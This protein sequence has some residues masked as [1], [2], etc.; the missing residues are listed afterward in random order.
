MSSFRFGSMICLWTD[1]GSAS[2][3]D[4]I[5]KQAKNWPS[6]TS[7][8]HQR[9]TEWRRTVFLASVEPRTAGSSFVSPCEWTVSKIKTNL[10]DKR[11]VNEDVPRSFILIFSDSS[12]STNWN[13]LSFWWFRSSDCRSV[14]TITRRVDLRIL[15]NRENTSR[16]RL[17]FFARFLFIITNNNRNSPSR[18]F[19]PLRSSSENNNLVEVR[20]ANRVWEPR[21]RSSIPSQTNP[22]SFLS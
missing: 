7:M 12:E 22:K 20:F 9:E 4:E 1:R 21:T 14:S 5:S 10:V 18:K 6:I 2:S 11:H 15:W 3:V 8:K 13:V 19:F 16:S 17:I